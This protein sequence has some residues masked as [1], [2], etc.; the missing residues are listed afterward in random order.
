MNDT[1]RTPFL[2]ALRVRE[3]RAL[4]LAEAFS[5]FGD[6]VARVALA[7]LVYAR[8]NSAALTALT[9][10]LTFLFALAGGFLLSGLADRFPRR[11]VIVVTD[12]VRA[13]LAAAM[14]VPGLPLWLLWSLIAVLAMAAAPFKAGQLALLRDVLPRDAYQAGLGLRQV[15]SQ[16][17]QVAGFGLGGVLVTLWG[18]GTS[19]LLNG[20][21]FLISAIIVQRWVRARP[22]ARSERTKSVGAGRAGV[23]G[24]LAAVFV[25]ASL[26]G[27]LVVPEGLAA[28]FASTVGIGAFGV[29]LL[30]AADPVGSVLG[31]LWAGSR[32]SAEVPSLRAVVGPAVLA[33]VP[34]VLSAVYANA[35]VAAVLWAICGM[36]STIYLIRMQAVA[37]EVVPK[38]RL[39]GVMGRLSTCLQTSQGVAIAGA[40]VVADRINPVST[41]ALSGCLAIASAVGAGVV[42]R[43][44]RPRQARTAAD[45]P[46]PVSMA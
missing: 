7:L 35:W 5:V 18:A 43:A 11:T 28:P 38:E 15:S 45:E 29:G 25:L 4:W 22:A 17:A 21:T 31:G 20:A 26:T 1:K 6:Q 14:A 32:G 2:K 12:L 8:T 30:M 36:F 24:R 27:L 33:G 42:W 19:L 39:G 40:G 23:D 44:A 37:A 16:I 34:L 10:A 9:Y 3:Y 41:V 13:A 46:A